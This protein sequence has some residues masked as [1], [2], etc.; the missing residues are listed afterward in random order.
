MT[1]GGIRF[2]E[3]S[4][5]YLTHSWNG[6]NQSEPASLSALGHL[7]GD[8]RGLIM[9]DIYAHWVRW[10]IEGLGDPN[11]LADR[12]VS[13]AA[14]YS[15]VRIAVTH[16]VFSKYNSVEDTRRVAFMIAQSLKRTAD[17]TREARR[18][19]RLDIGDRTLLLDIA[20]A[21]PRCWICGFKFSDQ[22]IDSFQSRRAHSTA[23][24]HF[25]DLLMPRGLV[26]RDLKIEVDH[27]TPFARGGLDESNLK[28]ACGWCNRHKGANISIYDVSPSPRIAPQNS[29]GIRSLPHPLWMVRML[30][31]SGICEA[32]TGCGASVADGPLYVAARHRDGAMN[33]TNLML[34]CQHHDPI[35][36][37]R[38]QPADEV[39]AIW[40]RRTI[41]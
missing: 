7:F 38:L 17:L 22:A 21:S 34:T 39:R 25:V 30:A 12:E 31:C 33:P 13:F 10:F 40:A 36:N 29:H 26:E 18:R 35:R 9:G 41:T 1:A 32:V 20:G 15:R 16:S 8:R 23:L 27:V 6:V 28:L 14:L 5:E 19:P 4:I 24:P 3:S 37:I 11:V 2:I